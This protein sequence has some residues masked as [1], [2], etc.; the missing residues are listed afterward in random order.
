MKATQMTNKIEIPAHI[1]ALV[2]GL[3]VKTWPVDTLGDVPS[4]GNV[5]DALAY[6]RPG[7]AVAV[8]A[9]IAFRGADTSATLYR[10][11]AAAATHLLGVTSPT[12][13]NKLTTLCARGLY[14]GYDG[15]G[16]RLT[17]ASFAKGGSGPGSLTRIELAKVAAKVSKPKATKPAKATPVI[18][19]APSVAPSDV[20]VTEPVTG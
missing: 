13:R 10:Q 9:C 12:Q 4:E 18:A 5:T 15:N 16:K 14:V 6:N 7:S 3:R 8:A 17:T 2:P 20:T 11:G 1:K 19:E